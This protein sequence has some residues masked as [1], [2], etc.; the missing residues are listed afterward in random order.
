MKGGIQTDYPE[1][2]TEGD[3]IVVFIYSL[4]IVF[5]VILDFKSSPVI[6][7]RIDISLGC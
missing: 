2:T 7:Q 6:C 1:T 5:G 3:S 4:A